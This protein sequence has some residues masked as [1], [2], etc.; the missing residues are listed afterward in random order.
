MNLGAALLFLLGAIAVHG[1]TH[2]TNKLPHILSELAK[3]NEFDTTFKNHLHYIK[4]L[5]E[6]NTNN[7]LAE[8]RHISKTVL[9]SLV[10]GGFE[11]K[12]VMGHLQHLI[13]ELTK[14]TKEEMCCDPA[15]RPPT[16]PG[17]CFEGLSCCPTTGEWVCSIGDG[18]TFPC[19]GMPNA[20]GMACGEDTCAPNEH[21]N[22]CGTACPANCD[23]SG[24]PIP[25]I[26]VCVAG[27]FCNPGFVRAS[28]HAD[29]PCV[30]V[31]S[32]DDEETETS[33]ITSDGPTASSSTTYSSHSRTTSTRFRC[34]AVEC[35]ESPMLCF[36]SPC[37]IGCPSN[38]DAVCCP[39]YCGE[40][41]ADWYVNGEKI[42]CHE[43]PRPKPFQVRP[44]EYCRE[45]SDCSQD[46]FEC[47]PDPTYQTRSGICVRMEMHPGAVRQHPPHPQCTT[48][49]D[50][51]DYDECT[52]NVCHSFKCRSFKIPNCECK[53]MG[54]W[55]SCQGRCVRDCT[56]E[57][58]YDGSLN[59]NDGICHHQDEETC[60]RFGDMAFCPETRKCVK[61]CKGCPGASFDNYGV[62][63]NECP[64]GS[65]GCPANGYCMDDC[66]YCDHYTKPEEGNQCVEASPQT[67]HEVDYYYCPSTRECTSSCNYCPL[68]PVHKN[69][70]CF[71]PQGGQGWE[72]ESRSFSTSESDPATLHSEVSPS[73]PDEDDKEESEP[74]C[75]EGYYCEWS[76]TMVDSCCRW[77]QAMGRTN[78]QTCRCEIATDALEYLLTKSQWDEFQIF[79]ELVEFAY[80]N[81]N[82]L[83]TRCDYTVLA[84]T[85]AAF[86]KLVHENYHSEWQ[87]DH[88]LQ[89][90]FNDRALAKSIVDLHLIPGI[91]P[92]QRLV[93]DGE[94][95]TFSLFRASGKRDFVNM[96]HFNRRNDRQVTNNDTEVLSDN[97]TTTPEVFGPGYDYWSRDVIPNDETKYDT[98]MHNWGSVIGV[99]KYMDNSVMHVIDIVIMPPLCGEGEDGTPMCEPV[100][101][102]STDDD[103]FDDLH[104]GCYPATEMIHDF[105][106]NCATSHQ[107]GFGDGK[108]ARSQ[109]FQRCKNR[110]QF[111]LKCS[112]TD[113]ACDVPLDLA[114]Q[115]KDWDATQTQIVGAM[116]VTGMTLFSFDRSQGRLDSP[117]LIDV[118]TSPPTAMPMC[119]DKPAD[120]PE[121]GPLCDFVAPGYPEDQDAYN[122]LH[123]VHRYGTNELYVLRVKSA[124]V[125]IYRVL[126]DDIH[127]YWESEWTQL[128]AGDHV[129][130]GDDPASVSGGSPG[131]FCFQSYGD[132]LM[133]IGVLHSGAA[134]TTHI[135]EL[136][137]RSR[138]WSHWTYS[139]DVLSLDVNAY[140]AI[141]QGVA[142]ALTSKV[143]DPTMS[144]N[145][146]TNK[147]LE[148]APSGAPSHNAL[149]AIDLTHTPPKVSWVCTN[150]EADE[151]DE[152]S[153]GASVPA[154]LRQNV[155]INIAGGVLYT[156]GQGWSSPLGSDTPPDVWR[157]DLRTGVPVWELVCGGQPW[158]CGY[159]PNQSSLGQGALLNGECVFIGSATTPPT[160]NTPDPDWLWE[161][162]LRA[163][164][165][166]PKNF[167]LEQCHWNWCPPPERGDLMRQ[168]A[169][170]EES[171]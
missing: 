80:P 165:T 91:R 108:N 113:D 114:A 69:G 58:G 7:R 3:S 30:P 75:S 60:K 158:K 97:D 70:V 14:W 145:F 99:D 152:W 84:P 87:K 131:N 138:H 148:S 128:C 127:P 8:R 32:C 137:L 57:C 19:P 46:W 166:N 135:Y 95:P 147:P 109:C 21:F 141:Y 44:F 116:E 88:N 90:L 10:Q 159:E 15:T 111:N 169:L 51:E 73:T 71:Y 110:P 162:R 105:N 48:D 43:R 151:D 68:N 6:D 77:C 78:K 168:P 17:G 42:D 54:D 106:L 132:K 27:C 22:E 142:Y 146:Y 112:E 130:S 16:G 129:C 119:M 96:L 92:I 41:M 25:C 118:S 23:N 154:G 50:C 76:G 101:P 139:S 171:F 20:G 1:T 67:C 123:A 98:W 49:K 153:C 163:S 12:Q 157:M 29:A 38:P 143:I 89:A 104:M 149:I 120:H 72:P 2:N 140:C 24:E 155:P 122:P 81:P 26:R 93:E 144:P 94:S 86:D 40:C 36:D 66:S 64:K 35:N 31:D 4:A 28:D 59:G 161:L 5:A 79:S 103:C 124:T 47:V 117:Y 11:S 167:G 107:T 53:S 170:P 34:P 125:A 121:P 156:Y 150:H 39:S 65:M 61:S 164:Q 63:S 56:A 45:D 52:H 83:L 82:D 115:A 133:M 160:G 136:D 126:I 55:W 33:T 13:P 85:D 100:V 134:A 62:C 74:D 9:T 18:Q 37:N 102:C